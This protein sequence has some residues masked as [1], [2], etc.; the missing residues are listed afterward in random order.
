MYIIGGERYQEDPHAKLGGGSEGTVYAHPK[1]A[2]LC[3]KLFHPPDKGDQAAADIAAYRAR[4]VAAICK[5][6][7]KL[8][9]QF[10]LP[11]IPAL[12]EHGRLVGYQM[13]RV[14]MGF[15][16][17]IKLLEPAFRVSNKF[18]LQ[19]VIEL[20]ALIFEDLAIPHRAGLVIGD[21][22]MGCLMFT[23]D[24]KRAWVDTDSWTYPGF[25]CLATT[26][27]FAHP[28]LYPN[29]RKG[30]TFVEPKAHHDAFAF[31]VAFTMMALPGAHPFRMGAHGRVHGLQDRATQGITIFD[32]EVTY[33]KMLVPP[34]VLSDDLL[35]LMIERLK[36]LKSEPL[37]PAMLREFAKG[38]I[39]CNC[40]EQYH[41]SR[42]ACP[43]CAKTTVVDMTA[44]LEFL[45]KEVFKA[46][47]ALLFAQVIDNVVNLVCRVGTKARVV[48]VSDQGTVTTVTTELPDTRGARYRF[49]GNYLTV[50]P[51]PTAEAPATIQVY[52][53]DGTTLARLADTSTGV[54]ENESAVYDTSSRFL[55]RTAGNSLMRS[56]PFG[57]ALFVDEPIAQ[58]HTNQS[59]FAVD[60][61]SGS[62]REVIFGYDRAL[63]DWEWFVIQG[64]KDGKG[65]RYHKVGTLPLRP[66]E[67]LE[68][69][70][71]YF[72]STSVLL[73]RKT[74]LQGRE[75]VRYSIIGLD[76]QVAS[77]KIVS[78][79]DDAFKYWEHLRGKLFQGTSILHVT[80]DGI[81]KQDL[82]SGLCTTL[83]DT[84]GVVTAD[85]RLIRFGRTV[86][87][88]RH[89]G[90][91]TMTKK[92]GK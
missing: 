59:W 23:P 13:P 18:G 16:K 61:M 54:L 49:F 48:R 2:A 33:P 22:N 7:L 62:D 14:P 77:D 10:T 53:I 15:Y 73:V 32:K 41:G 34:E 19:Q 63:R 70:A 72:N 21:I 79:D 6:G 1:D 45:I 81:T 83:K 75:F 3:V 37:D 51:N 89:G 82:T 36:R 66:G 76:G 27:M 57:A 91:L 17:L 58:V 29:L 28:D 47:G 35:N 43:K 68:D 78:Q 24:F 71:V 9:T 39:T 8:P 90:V 64:G 44:L 40:G 11:Q 67:G 12:D 86:G 26:E 92:L 4:K 38:V 84:T 31:L 30:G 56:E 55:Y 50:C 5:L 20:Y 87:I 65:F 69:F 46:P 25:P 85:D 52:R 74:K 42:K 88:I 60:H 80:P